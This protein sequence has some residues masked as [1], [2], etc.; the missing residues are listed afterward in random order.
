VE[1]LGENRTLPVKDGVFE[2]SFNDWD[3]HLYH[4]RSSNH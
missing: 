1:V 4:R 2:D 3:A